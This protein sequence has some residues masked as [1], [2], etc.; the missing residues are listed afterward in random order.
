VAHALAD[1]AVLSPSALALTKRLLYAVDTA[2]FDT[3]IAL[4]ARVNAA[5]RGTPD[6]RQA[7][8]RFL[9]R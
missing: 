8:E 1:L 6:F 7:L 4:G 5:A 3:A 2:E 9:T